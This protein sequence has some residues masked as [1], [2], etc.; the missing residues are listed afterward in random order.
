P[1]SHSPAPHRPSATYLDSPNVSSNACSL[2]AQKSTAKAVIDAYTAWDIDR[3]LSYRTPEC[4]HQVLPSSMG[5]GPESNDEY[6]AYLSTIMPLYSEFTV[7]VLKEIQDAETHTCLIY[8]SSTADTKI[9]RYGN[10]YALILTFT[11]D[12]RHG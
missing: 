5:R 12:G 4:Q 1:P 9:G 10:E 3:I 11:E 2:D 8:A 7:A 6:R